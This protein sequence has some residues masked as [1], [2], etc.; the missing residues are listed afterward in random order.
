MADELPDI[1]GFDALVERACEE[2]AHHC[3]HPQGMAIAVTPP[4][5]NRKA[6][7]QSTISLVDRAVAQMRP[8][9]DEQGLEL[10]YVA[11]HCL[12]E[13][14]RCPQLF[15]RG[16]VT[17]RENEHLRILDSIGSGHERRTEFF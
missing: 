6:C 5:A 2:F 13:G 12:G 17:L 1:I 10:Q 8:G 14:T 11:G 9:A 4:V 16:R 15:Q 3:R 7:A